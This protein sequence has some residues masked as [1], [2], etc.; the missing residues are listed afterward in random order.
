MCFWGNLWLISYY[1][2]SHWWIQ[3][4][5]PGVR[6][7]LF[8]KIRQN[9]PFLFL[10]PPCFFLPEP[11]LFKL[12]WMPACI[13]VLTWYANTCETLCQY[14][15]FTFIPT[16]CVSDPA[17]VVFLLDR[18]GSVGSSAFQTE[19]QFIA[20]FAKHYVIGPRNVQIGIVTFSGSP[21][22]E[23]DLKSF[24]DINELEKKVMRIKYRYDGTHTSTALRFV[25]ENS[26]SAAAGDRPNVPNFLIVITDGKSRPAKFNPKVEAAK[27]HA[28]NI[29]VFAIG[30][31]FNIAID[32]LNV[33]GTDEHHVL[34]VNDHHTLHLPLREIRCGTYNI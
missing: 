11:L 10:Y 24:H 14:Y 5:I 1:C 4:R 27:L 20:E 6:T 15:A 16:G 12:L 2:P 19:L 33:I 32:E 17:D 29:E 31:G 26:F 18:S 3:G 7:S 22:K 23:F 21:T 9:F 34:T 13:V 8:Q 25:R 28:T 30:V